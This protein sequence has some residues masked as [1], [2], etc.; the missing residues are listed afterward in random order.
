MGEIRVRP[1]AVAGTFYP[2]DAVEL[3]E[4]VDRDLEQVAVEG[5]VPKAIV[6]P[7]AG[8]VYSGPI[9]AS[10]Y[11]RLTPAHDTIKRV[12]LLGPAHRVALDGM[13]IPSVDAMETPLGRVAIDRDARATV[14]EH[15]RL[16]V[17][18]QPHEGEHSLEV[19]LPFLQR[20]LS[21]GFTVLPIVVGRTGSD[22]V[23][24][25]L[26]LVWGGDETLIVVSSD[27]SHYESYDS[28]VAHDRRTAAA[29]VGNRPG[30]IGPT[31][32][33]GVFPLKGLLVA[34]QRRGL[35]PL[36]LDLRNSGDTAGDKRQVVGYGA[37]A[38]H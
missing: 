21:D 23:A 18:D 25:V 19:H 1:P 12:V 26:E 29:V 2:A 38:L 7:H 17:D 5:P 14:Q 22:A 37:F 8:L 30:E 6:A 28:A 24:D 31:D 13:A 32:A 15:P 4:I 34:A 10:A 20:V 33:C 11:S 27:L 35:E 3:A 36:L 9:A 16:W